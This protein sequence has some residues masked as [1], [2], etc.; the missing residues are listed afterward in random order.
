MDRPRAVS[1]LPP[2]AR[3]RFGARVPPCL[4]V[5]RSSPRQPAPPQLQPPARRGLPAPPP[6]RPLSGPTR[7]SPHR[8]NR[9]APSRPNAQTALGGSPRPSTPTAAHARDQ[10]RSHQPTREFRKRRPDAGPNRP[11]TRPPARARGHTNRPLCFPRPPAPRPRVSAPARARTP[12]AR[13]TGTP[14]QGRARRNRRATSP[15]ERPQR[16]TGPVR[17][18]AHELHS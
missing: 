17:Y 5:L 9:R 13:R 1:K 11:P 12:S 3:S 8:G 15:H 4:R 10:G 2:R 16:Q 6:S 7:L 14:A 18:A